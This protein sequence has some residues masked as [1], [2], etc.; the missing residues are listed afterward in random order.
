[1]DRDME[2]I[3]ESFSL[4][5]Y[6]SISKQKTDIVVLQEVDER[7]GQKLTSLAYDYKYKIVEQDAKIIDSKANYR[8]FYDALD[9]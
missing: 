2:S 5:K 7:W 3:Q 8:A 9:Q 4:E 1:M 6:K